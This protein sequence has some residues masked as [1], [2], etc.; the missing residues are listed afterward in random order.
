M[1]RALKGKRFES[2]DEQN[3]WLL[4]WNESWASTRIHG[5]T[6]RQVQ[7]MFN[8]ERPHLLPL[9][10]TRFEYYQIAERR[11]HLDGHI[12]VQAAYYSVPPRYVGT[13]VVVHIGRLWLRILDRYTPVD[14]RACHN[15]SRP[16]THHRSR[17][18][19]QT[20]LKVLDLVARIAEFG[21]HCGVFARA[22]ENERGALAA[23][24]L[25]GVLDLIRRHG[26]QNV[27]RACTLAVPA[28]PA[29]PLSAHIL[30]HHRPTPLT[31]E[32]RIIPLIDTYQQH[33]T[34]LAQGNPHD[35]STAQPRLRQLRL[36]GSADTLAV[37]AQQARADNLGPLDFLSLLVHD[38]LDR[39]RVVIERRVKA[40]VFRD[41]KTLDTFDWKFNASI[42]RGADGRIGHRKVHRTAARL[43]QNFLG[44]PGSGKSHLA[45]AIGMTAILAG[46]RVIY[47]EAHV[48]FEELLLAAAQPGAGRRRLQRTAR[49]RCSSSTILACAK[50]PAAA[51]EIVGYCDAT[52]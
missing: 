39:R 30:A 41:R 26:P 8:E 2:T 25:L 34:T 37:R 28:A 42:H 13:K 1:Q 45:Q 47:R 9:P 48:L 44:N 40:A 14:P 5:T 15:R 4:R 24:T 50:F 29:L 19:K 6:K 49:Y 35:N 21:P 7:A 51:A 12:E 38:E 11:V 46:F 3:A 31:T 43:P 36:G 18:T 10:P 52:S 27:E 20:P 33:F 22:V 17:S 23:R 32:H 16:A